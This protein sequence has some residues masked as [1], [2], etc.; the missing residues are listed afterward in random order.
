MDLKETPYKFKNKQ[1]DI[2]V[3]MQ[4]LEH[5]SPNQFSI[6]QEMKRIAKYVIITLPYKWNYAHIDINH[7]MIDENTINKWTN[8]E[9]YYFKF[10]NDKSIILA[11]DFRG[12]KG[13]NI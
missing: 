3:A 13:D 11:Y 10:I 5:L 1:Y 2:C 12:I 6:F 9:P 8:N 7:H 4:V